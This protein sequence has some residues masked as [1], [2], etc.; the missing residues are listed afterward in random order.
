MTTLKQAREKNKLKEFIKEREKETPDADKDRFDA[1]L[2]S[3]SQGKQSK[4][5]KS[6]D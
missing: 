6:S 1:A 4:D 3:M 5:Q 2:K